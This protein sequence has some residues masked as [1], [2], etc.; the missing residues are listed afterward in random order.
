[1]TL[2]KLAKS[3]LKYTNLNAITVPKPAQQF[4]V[5]H[6]LGEVDDYAEKHLDQ[7]DLVLHRGESV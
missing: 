6:S 2:L 3:K 1:M 5:L 7:L 4:Q